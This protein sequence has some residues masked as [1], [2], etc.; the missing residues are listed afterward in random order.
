MVR[1]KSIANFEF[2]RVT[3][4]RFW[5]ILWRYVG[6]H[7]PHLCRQVQ[8]IF[9][10][11][12]VWVCFGSS[13]I[14]ASSVSGTK[15]NSHGGPDLRNT[16]AAAT[17]LCCFFG[18]KFARKQRC[19]SRGVIVVQKPIF[20]LSQIRAFPADCFVQIAHNLQVICL[21]DIWHWK[22]DTDSLIHFLQSAKI[23]DKPK[24][25]QAKKMSKIN[26]TFKMV[27]L[28]CISEEYEYQHNATKNRK[29]NIRN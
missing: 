10:S 25:I 17:L 8:L 6:T 15:D 4:S 22:F 24:R 29:S 23:E 7:I 27:E 12:V 5:I 26:W 21:I 18:K 2:P 13:S 19:V 11:Y 9:N 14:F 28:V 16:V 1:S 20:V 3:Y